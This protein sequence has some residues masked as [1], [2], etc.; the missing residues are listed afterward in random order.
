M[1]DHLEEG[2]KGPAEQGLALLLFCLH[3]PS[4]FTGLANGLHLLVDELTSWVVVVS[5]LASFFQ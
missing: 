1:L 3:F 2:Y 4:S 5:L